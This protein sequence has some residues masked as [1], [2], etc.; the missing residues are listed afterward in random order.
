MSSPRA[1]LFAGPALFAIGLAEIWISD[2]LVGLGPLSRAEAQALGV[3][4]LAIAPGIAALAE[5]EEAIRRESRRL[6]AA[7]AIVLGILAAVLLATGVSQVGCRP[8]T[9]PL[10]VAFQ[11]AIVGAMAAATYGLA[12]LVSTD[13]ARKGRRV[14]AILTGATVFIGLAVASLLVMV[15]V[16]FPPLSCG[17]PVSS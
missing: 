9:S 16:L 11:A 10:D 12:Y 5:H 6:A 8:V 17:A 1:R 3:P 13:A 7:A 14:T 4:F 2:L 15:T